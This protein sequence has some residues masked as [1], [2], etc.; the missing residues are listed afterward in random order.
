MEIIFYLVTVAAAALGFIISLNIHRKKKQKKPLVCP[1]RFHCDAVVHSEYSTFFKIPLEYIG[2][3]YYATI[4][5]SYM[6]FLLFPDMIVHRYFVV[7]VSGA[8]AFAF[9]FSMYLIGIQAFILKQWCTWCIMSAGL[10][11]LIFFSVVQV[12]LF[13]MLPFIQNYT[14]FIVGIHLFGVILGFGGALVTDI[15]FVKFLKDLKIVK[16]ELNTLKTF[17]QIIWVGLGII[18]VSGSLLFLSNPERYLNSAK[19]PVKMIAVGVIIFNGFILNS[20]VT[21]KLSSIPFGKLLTSEDRKMRSMRRAV[22]ALGAV[23][24]TSWWTAFVLGVMNRSPAPFYVILG[25]YLLLLLGAV[26]VSQILEKVI[27]RRKVEAVPEISVSSEISPFPVSQNDP[28]SPK[29]R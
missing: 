23:S 29:D 13:D 25:I 8:T 2:M 28:I 1:L 14:M 3:L 9:L 20:V 27:S 7:A 4:F 12:S 10:C 17:S 26:V 22:F 6:S 11:V 24:T 19:F 16:E 21:P 18:L 5:L 15:F